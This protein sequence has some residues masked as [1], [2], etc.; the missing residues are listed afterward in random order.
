MDKDLTETDKSNMPCPECK[1]AIIRML[2]RLE[3]SIED[4]RG[5]LTTEIK[6]IKN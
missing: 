5:Y 4:S 2:C 3:K 1:V 6:D